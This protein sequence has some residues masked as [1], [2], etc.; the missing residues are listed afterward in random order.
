MGFNRTSQP[1]DVDIVLRL[2]ASNLSALLKGVSTASIRLMTLTLDGQSILDLR[3]EPIYV[4]EAM[5]GSMP[6]PVDPHPL[7]EVDGLFFGGG[8]DALEHQGA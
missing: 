8:K 3:G 7:D 5:T 2:S 4:L 1:D 6:N